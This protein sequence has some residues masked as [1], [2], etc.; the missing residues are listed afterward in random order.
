MAKIKSPRD[1]AL[2]LAEQLRYAAKENGWSDQL[3]ADQLG[4][5]RQS[6]NKQ[7]SGQ[8]AMRLDSFIA[9]CRIVGWE[10]GKLLG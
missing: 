7:L 1:K 10:P 8:I 3:I 4:V 6:I 9:I 2:I 5:S